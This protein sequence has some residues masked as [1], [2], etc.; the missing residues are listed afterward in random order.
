MLPAELDLTAELYNPDAANNHPPPAF[1]K[2]L[3][4]FHYDCGHIY[5]DL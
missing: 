3:P 1:N 4:S 5:S 2:E